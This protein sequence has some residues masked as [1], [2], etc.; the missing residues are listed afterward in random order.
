MTKS[1][2][3]GTTERSQM[4]E[5]LL[6]RRPF[7]RLDAIPVAPSLTPSQE[8]GL[9]NARTL[10]EDDVPQLVRALVDHTLAAPTRNARL[11]PLF[12]P[13]N[14]SVLNRRRRVATEW[15]RAVL[16]GGLDEATLRQVG[17]SWLPQLTG[18][19][20][21]PGAALALGRECFEYVRG[22]FAARLLDEPCDNLV[23][24]ALA[25]DAVETVLRAHLRAFEAA[26][27]G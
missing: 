14:V 16:A 2:N 15:L 25:L 26:Q 6:E 23:P 3:L 10:C 8:R 20:P 27:L 9:C 24:R 18:A 13:V 19:G 5:A 4:G 1:A 22:A 12:G 17:R 21:E 7:L 11:R